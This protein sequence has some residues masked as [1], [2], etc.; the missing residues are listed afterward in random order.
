MKSVSLSGSPRE[1]VGKKDAADLRRNGRVPCVI[2]GAEEQVH[3]HISEVELNKLVFTPDA[4]KFELDIDGKTY[5]GVIQ[6]MQ[7]HP[8]SD[9]ILHVDFLEL[10]DGKIVK[11]KLPVNISG[12]SIGV[13]NGGKLRQNFR[14]L[15]LKGLPKDFPDAVDV[16]ISP[17]RIGMSVRVRDIEIPGLTVLEPAGAVIV[18]V[19]TARGVIDEEEE[20]EEGAEG[21]EGAAEGA[22]GGDAPAEGGEG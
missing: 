17:L 8:V 7:W 20:E 5:T 1:N 2:Y 10:V 19:K 16:D 13:R 15:T 9:R 3:F 12:N 11:I 18:G 6:D 21:E 4:Y 14:S 22:E